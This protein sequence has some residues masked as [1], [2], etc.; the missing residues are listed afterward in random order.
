MRALLSRVLDGTP[1][2]EELYRSRFP[3]WQWPA[4]PRGE[5]MI[6]LHIAAGRVAADPRYGEPAKRLADAA[7]RLTGDAAED[8]MRR[9]L[10]WMNRIVQRRDRI[11]ARWRSAR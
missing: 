8:T 3:S 1:I 5:Y 6:A 9:G 10:D 7:R 11:D 2:P 4:K